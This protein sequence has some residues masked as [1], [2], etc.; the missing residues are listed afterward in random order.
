MTTVGV[1]ISVYNGAATIGQ[2]LASV[3]GQTRAPDQ[4]VVVDDGSTDGTLPIVE[5]W[6]SVLPLTIVRHGVNRGLSAGRMSAIAELDTDVILA[7]DSDD[8]WLPH[9]LARL[10]SA[11]AA[12][13]GIVSPMAVAWRPGSPDPIDWRRP[14][15]PKPPAPDL[16]HLLI[17]NW[18]FSGALFARTAY[19][20]AGGLYRF[21]GCEDWDLWLRM[22]KVDVPVRVLSEPTV[23]YRLHGANM[24]ADDR[25][26]PTEVQVLETFLDET[27]DPALRAAAHRSLRHRLARLALRSAY[28]HA[29]DGRS[30]AA[31]LAAVKALSGPAPVA[32]RGAAMIVAPRRT[33]GRRDRS[34]GVPV[35]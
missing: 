27:T 20:A 10:L 7:I 19:Y 15:Q 16:S 25:V 21:V 4:V 6:R 11:Y 33:V 14:L 12:R 13:P 30:P 28:D 24:S 3:A 26:L 17:M 34:R 8:V 23:L 31:R 22:L 9:H 5:T 32:V 35:R 29:R 2:A 1:G 18:L